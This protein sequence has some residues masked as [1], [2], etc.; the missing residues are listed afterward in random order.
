[1]GEAKLSAQV[2]LSDQRCAQ[3]HGYGRPNGQLVPAVQARK[4]HLY[5]ASGRDKGAGSLTLA[6][7]GARAHAN[8]LRPRQ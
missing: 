2:R 7:A 3:Q 1:M 4:E 5:R 8:T 6:Y